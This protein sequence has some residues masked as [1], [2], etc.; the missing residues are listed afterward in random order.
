M[1]HGIAEEIVKQSQGAG[2]ENFVCSVCKNYA[3]G[4]VC[5]R[6][7][8]I[9]FEGADVSGCIYQEKGRACPHCGRYI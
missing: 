1:S 6:G 5:E 2:W 4:C 9:A 8:F 3:G 7:V